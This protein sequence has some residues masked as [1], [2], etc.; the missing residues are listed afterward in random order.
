[1]TFLEEETPDDSTGTRNN[2]ADDP[3]ILTTPSEVLAHLKN[4]NQIDHINEV[5]N[6]SIDLAMPQ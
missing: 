3:Y 1:M 6:N 2:L 4:R 5:N